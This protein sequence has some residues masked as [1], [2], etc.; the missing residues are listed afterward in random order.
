M[1]KGDHIARIASSRDPVTARV[2]AE[3]V[4]RLRDGAYEVG[5]A[6]P[7]E[8]ALAVEFG[9]SRLVS[10]NAIE[11]LVHLGYVA[12]EPN[13][14]PVVLTTRLASET[15]APST[16]YFWR[17]IAEGNREADAVLRGVQYE[18]E[19]LGLNVAH[20]EA[21]SSNWDE[22][23]HA[24]E[25]FLSDAIADTNTFGIVLWYVGG[26]RNLPLLV[27]ARELN[28][29]IVFVDR[30]PPAAFDADYVGVDNIGSATAVVNHLIALGHKR[31]AHISNSD[32][33]SPVV[34]RLAGYRRAMHHAK[35]PMNPQHVVREAPA[36]E[37]WQAP[38]RA[39]AYAL[40][41]GPKP[42]TALF[43]LNDRI[44]H[45]WT[46]VLREMGRRVPEDISVAGFDG[47][48]YWGNE[49]E[50]LTTAIQPFEDIGARAVGLLERRRQPLLHSAF[51]Q[52]LLEAPL[53]VRKSTALLP[54][55]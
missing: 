53:A 48:D 38:R 17:Y 47:I 45:G 13:C 29:P 51:R 10:R 18:A 40:L 42:P 49:F 3:L 44:A 54:R 5:Q 30:L 14:R 22:I 26:S 11:H 50:F 52:I 21:P 8:R 1:G 36:C 23:V 20:S 55:P 4:D 16:V 35:L 12:K 24:E 2:V 34:E 37:D 19:C 39:L 15:A 7:T 9:V 25:R 31:I 6:L 43:C 46:Q 28:I 41:D 27:R 32:T 33:A